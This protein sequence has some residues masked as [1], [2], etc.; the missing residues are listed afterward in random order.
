LDPK[1]LLGIQ[2]QFNCG[3]TCEY[4]VVLS[5]VRFLEEPA[6]PLDLGEADDAAADDAT[7]DDTATDDTATDDTAADDAAADDAS[8]EE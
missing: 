6:V 5:N 1:E 4:D 3:G 2:W 7:S 8:A